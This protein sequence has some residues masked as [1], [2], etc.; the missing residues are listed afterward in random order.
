M[1]EFRLPKEYLTDSFEQFAGV[2]SA[3]FPRVL[4][5]LVLILAGLLLANLVRWLV[6]RLGK[7]FDNLVNRTRLGATLRLKWPLSSLIAGATY[8]LILLVFFAAAAEALGLPGFSESLARLIKYIPSVLTGLAILVAGL[9]L[10]GI[11]RDNVVAGAAASRMAH[12]ELLGALI[13]NLVITLTVIIGL[14]Q[15]GLRLD[16]VEY[17]LLIL[18]AAAL[19][20]LALGFGLGAAPTVANIIAIRNVRRHYRVG[21]TVRVGDV[22]GTILELS[23]A[24]VVLDTG[25][26]RTLVPAKAFEE[27]MSVLL[28]AEGDGTG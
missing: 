12:G 18:A 10:G 6:V 3:Y 22:E 19:F 17:L 28:E 7:G 14:E 20:A 11:A 5:A 8:W 2:V 9:V 27:Q 16:L 23:S 21:Q 25:Q 1:K 26:G 24:F 4:T 15:L 13:R